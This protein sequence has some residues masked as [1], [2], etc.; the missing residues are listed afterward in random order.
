[1]PPHI[2]TVDER[3]ALTPLITHLKQAYNNWIVGIEVSGSKFTVDATIPPMTV[4]I[5]GICVSTP[6]MAVEG[7]TREKLWQVL[8]QAED[9]LQ[10]DASMDTHDL[11][12]AFELICGFHSAAE[13]KYEGFS[14]QSALAAPALN[15]VLIA[16]HAFKSHVLNAY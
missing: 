9:D 6:P 5:E 8:Q 2:L 12:G 15:T 7:I 14:H 10:N 1:M 3:T 4:T 16:F 11:Y 13:Q